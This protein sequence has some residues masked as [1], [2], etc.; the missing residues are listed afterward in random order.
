MNKVYDIIYKID[1]KGKTRLWY[2]EQSDDKYRTWDG[3]EG[4]KIK[5]SEWRVEAKAKGVA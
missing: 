2:M 4:G 3:S 5:C 1:S